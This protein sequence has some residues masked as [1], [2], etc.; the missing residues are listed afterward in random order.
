MASQGNNQEALH[1]DPTLPLATALQT[2]RSASHHGSVT[3]TPRCQYCARPVSHSSTSTCLLHSTD[4]FKSMPS[5]RVPPPSS[6]QT[7]LKIN[8]IVSRYTS[9]N[10]SIQTQN[11]DGSLSLEMSPISSS[12]SPSPIY[13]NEPTPRS[14]ISLPPENRPKHSGKTR[15]KSRVSASVAFTSSMSNLLENPEVIP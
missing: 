2:P 3:S 10:M 13:E 15:R 12:P 8:T 1:I 14:R 7:Q 9:S 11:A 4:S 6:H 5:S